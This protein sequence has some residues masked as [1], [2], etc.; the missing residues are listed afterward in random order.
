MTTVAYATTWDTLQRVFERV[1]DRVGEPVIL[2]SLPYMPTGHEHHHT[3]HPLV[4]GPPGRLIAI[5]IGLRAAL[6]D[7][8]IILVGASDSV[9][10]GTNHL[11]HAARRNIGM[12]LVMLRSDVLVDDVD[13]AG[14][15][16]EGDQARL[17][18][19][20]TPLEWATALDAALVGRGSI[21]DLDGLTDLVVEAVRIPGF[22]VIGVTADPTLRLGV[23]SRVDWPEFVASYRA[24]AAPM[25]GRGE[26]H[27]PVPTV[28]PRPGA[29]RRVEVRVAG[30]GGQGVK[31]AG[32]I[33]SE[34]AGLGEGLWATHHGEYGAATRGGPSKVD[35]VMGSEPI[36]YAGADHPDV[37]V[38]LS[39]GA[40]D[41]YLP[42]APAG[43]SL[44][45]DEGGV[46]PIPPGVLAVPISRLAREHTG[47]SIA[48]GVTSLGCVA[49]LTDAVSL[50]AM[51]AAVR[52]RVP[53]RSVEAN[54]S[55]L[56]AAYRITCDLIGG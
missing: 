41:T 10:L 49:A 29:P 37:L 51:H 20:G 39:Q 53:G 14:W 48:A 11:I 6:P 34:A 32:T 54:L 1:A 46:D 13:R 25:L 21:T 23:M 27:P 43:A 16:I 56:D 45:A 5:A 12:T 2:S 18:S 50:D 19:A 38:V 4:L 28:L 31:L 7:T 8:P 42:F 30:L 22:S 33:L 17:E 55:A 24:W 9:T 15:H 47:K 40:A 26:G 52:K 3:T 35:V 36:T 44:V